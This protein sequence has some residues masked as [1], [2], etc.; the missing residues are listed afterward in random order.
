MYC[1]GMKGNGQVF[2][3]FG[4]YGQV[5]SGDKGSGG[6]KILKVMVVCPQIL[7]VMVRYPQDINGH[8]HV[9]KF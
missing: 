6:S 9:S 3:G 4:G 7:M 2:P 8:A 1:P 5:S